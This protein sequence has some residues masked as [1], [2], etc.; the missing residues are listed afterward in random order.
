MRTCTVH[1]VA[2]ILTKVKRLKR[3]PAKNYEEE[4]ILY[5]KLPWICKR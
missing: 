5:L 1:T 3:A 4:N 2:F